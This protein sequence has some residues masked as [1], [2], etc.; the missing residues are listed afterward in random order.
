LRSHTLTH[1]RETPHQ[2][3]MCDKKFRNGSNLTRH[4]GTHTGERPHN[5]TD[6]SATFADKSSLQ[7]H[8]NSAVHRTYE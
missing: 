4:L 1:T 5:C 3:Q 6:C 8:Q 7:V 2:C